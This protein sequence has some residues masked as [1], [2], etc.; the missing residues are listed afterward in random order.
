M[1][2]RVSSAAA[3]NSGGL[4][5][6]LKLDEPV[7][8]LSPAQYRF[9]RF[10]LAIADEFG[11]QDGADGRG[12]VNA[13]DDHRSA[14]ALARMRAGLKLFEELPVSADGTGETD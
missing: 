13:G 12:T 10:V 11:A 9:L 6:L 1:A 3:L 14:R 7:P 2:D 5:Y 4:R 8:I